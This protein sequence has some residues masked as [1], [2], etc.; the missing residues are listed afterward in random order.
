[1]ANETT[2]GMSVPDA[3]RQIAEWLD[4]GREIDY[5]GKINDNWDKVGDTFDIMPKHY[6]YRAAPRKPRITSRS[7][8]WY[9][10]SGNNHKDYAKFVE[11]TDEVM[12]A[13]KAAGIEVE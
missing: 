2:K 12:A 11:L 1:M 7:M 4:D 6:I 9:D 10:I 8:G 3:L 13:C 5:Y